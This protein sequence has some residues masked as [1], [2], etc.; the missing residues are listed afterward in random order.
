MTDMDTWAMIVEN[1][2]NAV[3]LLRVAVLEQPGQERT[4]VRGVNLKLMPARKDCLLVSPFNEPARIETVE[5]S[6]FPRHH[7]MPFVK[8]SV[9]TLKLG[10]S[11]MESLLEDGWEEGD[12]FKGDLKCSGK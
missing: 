8:A 3:I 12:K 6:I 4:F 1:S 5:W 9:S 2:I 10:K 11:E 7:L